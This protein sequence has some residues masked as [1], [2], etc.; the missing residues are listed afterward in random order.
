VRPEDFSDANPVVLPGVGA[1]GAV[2]ESLVRANLAPMLIE[3]IASGA[4]FLGVCV[5]MQC[6]FEKSEESPGV[7]GLGVIKGEVVRFREGKVPQIGWN[8]IE[9]AKTGFDPGYVYFVNSYHCVPCDESA[10]LYKADY[11]GAFCAAVKKDNI[12]AFQFHPE[13]SVEFG[14]GLLRRW[15]DAL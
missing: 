5:G 9:P 12:T 8:R 14:Q 2:M 13:K 10:V 4:P 3:R 7:A 1:F 6:L 11:F 15:I